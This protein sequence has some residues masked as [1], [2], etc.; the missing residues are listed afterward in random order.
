MIHHSD[1]FSFL[2]NCEN[3]V[4]KF[5]VF[6]TASAEQRGVEQ[7]KKEAVLFAV[8]VTTCLL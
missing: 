4:L 8:K 5:S 6:D 3:F 7:M 1:L 2:H